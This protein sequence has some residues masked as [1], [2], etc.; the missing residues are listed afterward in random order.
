MVDDI[1][2]DPE[3]PGRIKERRAHKA[4]L[5]REYEE[6]QAE[7]ERKRKHDPFG[8]APE[9]RDDLYNPADCEISPLWEALNTSARRVFS[10]AFHQTVD[11]APDPLARVIGKTPL[12][13]H[14]WGPGDSD[15]VARDLDGREANRVY[16]YLDLSPIPEYRVAACLKKLGVRDALNVENSVSQSTLNRMPGRMDKHRRQFFANEAETL[17]RQWQG[18]Q[19]EDW[20]REPTPDTVAPDGQGVPPVQRLVRELRSETFKAIQLKRDSS[21]QVSKDAALRVLVTAANGNAFVTDA[22]KNLTLK[23]W[24]DGSEIPT[25]QTLRFHL[26]KSSREQTTRMFMEANE[27][28]FKI[29]DD[30]GYFDGTAEVAIDIT[31]WPYYGKKD[32]DIY[33]CG[34]KPT[35]NHARAWKY[36]TLSLV[37]TDTPLVLFVLP[38]RTTSNSPYYVR[39]L[40]RFASQYLDIER[41]YLD[42]GFYS[43]DVARTIEGFD[44]EFVIQAKKQGSD[45]KNLLR[46]M[47]RGDF[48]TARM[49]YGVG[50]RPDD[51]DWLVGVESDK[52][53][54]RRKSAADDP[55]DDYTL[56]YTNAPMDKLNELDLAAAY[57]NRWGIET[58]FRVIKEEFL[59]KSASPNARIRTF[60]F[61]FAAHLYN[62]W[63]AANIL[64]AEELGNDLSEGKK[65]T[66]GRLMQ[67]IED[68]QYD[69]DISTEISDPRNV[70]DELFL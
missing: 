58:G 15:H 69:L 37:G 19:F 52:K 12:F 27:H 11:D 54:S 26:Q 62:I 5:N 32:S 51:A 35:R 38:V 70:F 1:D 4:R 14:Y 2:R 7:L 20:V 33:I 22:A 49:K 30:H 68:D 53:S 55:I 29:A 16:L 6:R 64:R 61:N 47:V 44:I 65:F 9:T 8:G 10:P 25:G 63:T 31:D 23:P 36:I 43:S 59:A 34:T 40:L 21:I 42:S 60:Y 50:D 3:S 48:K 39:R 41:V 13:P 57:R 28:L 18:T 17:V 56:F 46:G 67:A 45:A 24:Y 66:A